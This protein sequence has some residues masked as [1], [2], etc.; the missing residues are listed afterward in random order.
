MLRVILGDAALLWLVGLGDVVL[1][2]IVAHGD[3]DFLLHG[4]GHGGGV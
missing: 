3:S 4:V 1:L 2:V